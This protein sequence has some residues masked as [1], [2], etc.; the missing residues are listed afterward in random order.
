MKDLKV[1]SK[2]KPKATPVFYIISAILYAFL[3]LVSTI[4]NVFLARMK[5]GKHE[6]A[7]TFVK[8][9]GFDRKA[10]KYIAKNRTYLF[11]RKVFWYWDVRI[12]MPLIAIIFLIGF[13]SVKADGKKDTEKL[14]F[15]ENIADDT[16]QTMPEAEAPSVDEEAIALARLADSVAKG[17]SDEVKRIIMWVAINRASDRSHGYGLSLLEEIARPKQW[18]QYDA[19]APYL[20]ATFALA[21]DVLTIW[22]TNGARPIYGDMLWFVLNEDGSVTVR[23]QFQK[24]KNRAEATFGQ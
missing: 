11:G 14:Y 23:N 7:K 3:G 2:N 17:R 15:E 12:W 10:G 18:Q 13:V 16:A 6:K 9:G 20:E 24:S 5:A 8:K 21:E 22:R 4:Q 19:N 1:A